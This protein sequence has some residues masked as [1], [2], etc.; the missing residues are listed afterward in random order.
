MVSIREEMPIRTRHARFAVPNIAANLVRILDDTN[1]DSIVTNADH[2]FNTN[3]AHNTAATA[4][5]ATTPATRS[6]W[7]EREI[8]MALENVKQ[9]R[10][11]NSFQL[12]P[13]CKGYTLFHCMW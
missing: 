8:E 9:A 5:A 4:P 3:N 10:C 2:F 13:T 6:G 1:D 7:T 11:G 12:W